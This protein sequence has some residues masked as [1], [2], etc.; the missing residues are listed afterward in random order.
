M[1][2]L[3]LVKMLSIQDDKLIKKNRQ[4]KAILKISLII[5]AIIFLSFSSS[6][7]PIAKS[8]NAN[9][10]INDII[11]IVKNKELYPNY[12]LVAAHRGYWRKHPENSLPAYDAAVEIG[13]DIVEMDIRLTSDDSLV[14][15]HDACLNR[16]TTGEGKLR[17]HTWNEVKDL[18][19]KTLNGSVTS[20]KIQ[21]L[22]QSLNHLKGKALMS[23]DIKEAGSL[24]DD[25]FKKAIEIA[26]ELGILNQLIIKGKKRKAD[27][28]TLLQQ[29]NA[30]LDDFIYTPIVFSTTPNLNDHLTEIWDWADNNKIH[31]VE[32]V[33]K[34][35]GDAI[36]SHIATA[37][38][39][40]LWVGQYSF[41]PEECG[42]VHAEKIPLTDCDHILRQY[43]FKNNGDFTN[44]LNDGRGDWDWLIS[45]G[46]DYIITDRPNL[47][48]N[49][50][51]AMG[52]RSL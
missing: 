3:F 21:T 37:Q 16:V 23:L 4:M 18:N 10:N 1:Y 22:R 38:S 27:L 41:W 17:D 25:T 13:A 50:F 47:M 6:N 39:K 8:L 42:G 29:V 24:Y 48:I 35:D 20:N 12:G 46:A 30:T 9:N 15:M 36:L 51:Q 40:G 34:Q 26:Q 44:F 33:Y 14:V 43:D 45:K 49:Y 32:L 28:E 7:N 5:S 31:A 2:G 11:H 52:K 19:L